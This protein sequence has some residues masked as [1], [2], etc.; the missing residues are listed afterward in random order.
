[1]ARVVIIV[2]E[3]SG[4]LLAA[5]LIEALRKRD[6]DIEIAGITGPRMRAAGCE[7]WGDYEQLAVMGLVEVIRH[8]PRLLRLMRLLTRRLRTDPPDLLIGVDAPD[9]NLR[10]LR[11]ARKQ[12]IRTLQYVCPSVWAWRSNRVKTIAAACDHVLCLLPFEPAFLHQHGI[13]AEF[14][15]HPL[16]DEIQ[17]VA[18][19]R[20]QPPVVAVLPGSRRGEVKYLGPEF[21]AAMAWLRDRIPGVTFVS[22]AANPATAA[23]FQAQADAAGVS[24]L[25]RHEASGARAAM[26]AADA[27]LLTSG[28]VTLEALLINR[29]MAVAYKVSALTA[30][31]L[32]NSG[33]VNIDR[34]SLPNL[35]A[36]R[37]LVPE[38][39][40]EDATGP[41]LGA[42]VFELLQAQA[43]GSELNAEFALLGDG[44]RCGASESA[45]AAVQRLLD[46]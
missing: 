28:T 5:G 7:S 41:Q 10:L 37:E 30:W 12:G 45:A 36:D 22:G 9:F 43:A 42:A 26:Q 8:L 39:I 33:L 18:P 2:G 25:L 21:A 6:P 32:R 40:Q 15:G 23:M 20:N 19:P 31:L 16:A 3:A 11:R 34:F 35:L 14:V 27:A 38:L 24:D 46:R 17:P 44:L 13:G 1:L 4:D 29:P